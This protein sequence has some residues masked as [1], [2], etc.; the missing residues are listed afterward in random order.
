MK[1]K[2]SILIILINIS[3]FVSAQ[4]L[5]D[6]IEAKDYALVEQYIK[7]GEKVNKANA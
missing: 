4:K 7:D 2:I 1:K 3:L 5:L 6:A